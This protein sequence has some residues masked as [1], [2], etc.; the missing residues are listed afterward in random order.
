MMDFLRI[1]RSL[2]HTLGNFSKIRRNVFYEK[3]IYWCSAINIKSVYMF[4][5]QLKYLNIKI[6]ILIKKL[7]F[8]K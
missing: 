3:N 2:R 1:I 7:Q 8:K 6:K 5:M 4:Y